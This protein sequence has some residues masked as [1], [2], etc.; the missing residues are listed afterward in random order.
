MKN[1]V[2]YGLVTMCSCVGIAL[3]YG[4]VAMN[5]MGFGGFG[6]YPTHHSGSN[7]GLFGGASSGGGI[8][9]MIIHRK[10]SSF[11]IIIEV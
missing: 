10:F 7:V 11:C 6:Y 5:N 1:T 4:S 3:C 2:L 8:F 9:E